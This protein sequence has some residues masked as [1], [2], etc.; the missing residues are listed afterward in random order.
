MFC[1]WSW[2][3]RWEWIH[4]ERRLALCTPVGRRARPQTQ[5]DEEREEKEGAQ[6]GGG[7]E[8]RHAV[9][10][11]P[12]LATIS[13]GQHWKYTIEGS[14]AT[15]KDYPIE[16]RNGRRADQHLSDSIHK[17]KVWSSKKWEHRE[18]G[19]TWERM[20]CGVGGLI[21]NIMTHFLFVFVIWNC[22]A[23]HLPLLAAGAKTLR[24]S[25]FI[26]SCEN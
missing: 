6:A 5:R 14:S 13:I 9:G 17:F 3:Q 19:E 12:C 1:S 10:Y 25:W 11:I 24:R 20:C 8:V 15:D 16:T 26:A 4:R 2:P 18:W 23:E 7:L 22:S 21:L